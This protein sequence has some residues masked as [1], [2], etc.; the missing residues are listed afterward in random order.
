VEL[1]QLRYFVA[2]A[3]RLNF[4]RAAE[5]L[6]IAQPALSAQMQK[7]EA[8]VGAPLFVR[9]KRHVELTDVGRMFLEEARV[10]LAH[11]DR[12]LEVGRAGASGALGRL[13]IGYN[14][15]FPFRPIAAI[16]KA[17]RD[18]RPSVDVRLVEHASRDQFEALLSADL[19]L[20][21]M[22]EPMVGFPPGFEACEV[23]T[24]PAVAIV[25]DDHPLA[26]RSAIG[27]E[28]LAHDSFIMVSDREGRES[29]REQV[30]SA[31]RLAGFTPSVVQEVAEPRIVLGLVGAG[32]G[33]SVMS[34][35]LRD[36]TMPGVCMIAIEPGR[37]LRYALVWP[38]DAISPTAKTFVDIAREVTYS[39]R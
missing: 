3:D 20:G 11:A 7:L 34:G 23:A 14:R 5:D 2:I 1:R 4:T 15:S 28:E 19:D 25:P 39:V 22:L 9:D 8:E 18:A 24:Y 10:T 37:I 35:A 27:L 12:T 13:S 30:L 29:H 31:C 36:F 16:V 32:L 38:E 26:Q 33:V 6:V 17:F 21:F